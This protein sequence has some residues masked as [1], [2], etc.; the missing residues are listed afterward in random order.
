MINNID[1][2]HKI[3]SL[4]AALFD[5]YLA[6]NR[7]QHIDCQMPSRDKVNAIIELFF[8]TI[9][10]GFFGSANVKKQEIGQ[11]L[12]N[13]IGA[14]A[15]LFYQQIYLCF[16]SRKTGSDESH[17]NHARQVTLM[18]LEALPLIR[19]RLS[20]DIISAYKGDPAAQDTDEIVFSY[21]SVIAMTI[22]RLAH[23]L[24]ELKVPLMPRMMSE[25]AHSRTGI[26]IHPGAQIG[27]GF[28][29]DHGTG[30]VI[31]ETAVI[32]DNCKL[33]QGVTLGAISFPHD[34]E[35]LII[36]GHKR[37][38]TLEDDVIVYSNASI[39]GNVI[40]GKGATI[41]GGVF[42]TSSVP[43]GCTVSSKP[44]ELKYRN[45]CSVLSRGYVPD[46]AI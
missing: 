30:V 3:D 1:I 7:L 12:R 45:R 46:F 22:Y 4:V 27:K 40:I 24:W 23:L 28:F 10:P 14:I 35:G 38:P 29:I 16:A 17:E 33:Y 8:E 31:G 39:L 36:R 19:E 43:P 18:V 34:E 13:Q 32:G 5:N 6:L 20:L 41:G 15:N 42:L 37:H 44:A 2:N 21:P 26:D 11:L 25:S 9:Y